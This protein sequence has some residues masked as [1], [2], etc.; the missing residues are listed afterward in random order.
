MDRDRETIEFIKNRMTYY[1]G[2]IFRH[3]RYNF[4]FY[5]I[6]SK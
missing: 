2:N 4:R 5:K 6:K 3:N 1:V